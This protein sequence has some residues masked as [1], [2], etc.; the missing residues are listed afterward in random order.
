MPTLSVNLNQSWTFG[1]GSKA[2]A[3]LIVPGFGGNIPLHHNSGDWQRFRS[4]PESCSSPNKGDLASLHTSQSLHIFSITHIMSTNSDSPKQTKIASFTNSCESTSPYPSALSLKWSEM[5]WKA[6]NRIKITIKALVC[7]PKPMQ[8]YI[9][10]PSCASNFTPWFKLWQVPAIF[11][12][13][14]PNRTHN[15]LSVYTG[16]VICGRCRHRDPLIL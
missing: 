1:P 4:M 5:H 15:R 12:V 2:R 16:Q 13:A 14:R 7:W 3:E 6:R 9:L 8:H 10:C 11:Y